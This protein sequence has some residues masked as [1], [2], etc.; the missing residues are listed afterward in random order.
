MAKIIAA[1][2]KAHLTRAQT[3]DY[4]HTL[5]KFLDK[6]IYKDN[7]KYL[8][9]PLKIDIF[10]PASAL[11]DDNFTH[12][13]I[14]A[15]NAYFAECGGFTGEMALNQ[16]KEFHIRTLLIGHSER[17]TLFGET[18]DFINEK[19]RFYRDAGF[20]IYYCVG[21]PLEVRQKG[22]SALK[23]FL[24]AQLSGIDI[25][26]GQL[27]IAYEP[28]WAIGT[29]VSAEPEAIEST[30]K[31]LSQFTDAPLLYGGSVNAQ[32]AAQILSLK[33]IDGVLVGSAS[34]KR[35]NFELII[36]AAL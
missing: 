1:N 21:E 4:V 35:E 26:Y 31:L 18:Q 10:P 2:F 20:W 34:L 23:D 15:Q 9:T 25:G 16:L 11:I 22:E 12:V 7:Q 27:I 3:Q 6:E 24:S 29:G 13:H 14:G 36:K 33:Y 30:L 32:N 17:R 8:Q 19:Y 28:I 5:D